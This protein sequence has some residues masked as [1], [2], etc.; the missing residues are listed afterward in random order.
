MGQMIGVRRNIKTLTKAAEIAPG[1]SLKPMVVVD[2]SI[3]IERAACAH[4]VIFLYI[5]EAG[6]SSG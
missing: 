4:P 2:V 5:F 3:R 6:P 1:E